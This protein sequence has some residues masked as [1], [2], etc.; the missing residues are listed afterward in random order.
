LFD[1]LQGVH[2]ASSAVYR[3]LKASREENLTKYVGSIDV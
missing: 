3:R 2:K 1:L